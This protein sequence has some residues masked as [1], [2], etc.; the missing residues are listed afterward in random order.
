MDKGTNLD[1]NL[2]N[3]SVGLASVTRGDEVGLL[4]LL[5]TLWNERRGDDV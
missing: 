1:S 2:L 3:A 4:E 5:K